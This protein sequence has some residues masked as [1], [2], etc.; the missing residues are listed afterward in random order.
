MQ[1]DKMIQEVINT[2]GAKSI[3]TVRPTE[4]GHPGEPTSTATPV[5]RRKLWSSVGLPAVISLVAIALILYLLRNVPAAKLEGLG[6]GLCV[7]AF[8]GF[9]ITRVVRGMQKEDALEE[10]LRNAD[11]ATVSPSESF[12]S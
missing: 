1:N 4:S 10:E 11:P 9:L 3:P 12:R 7:I 6:A 8:G 5:A 2:T